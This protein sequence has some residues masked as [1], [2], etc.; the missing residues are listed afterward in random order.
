MTPERKREIVDA[1]RAAWPYAPSM[2]IAEGE[3]MAVAMAVD[4][5]LDNYADCSCDE[6][7]G[8]DCWY[9]LKDAEQT[10]RIMATLP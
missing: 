2:V 1:V 8:A 9:R 3:E 4:Y 7:W 5:Y 10:A 6:G